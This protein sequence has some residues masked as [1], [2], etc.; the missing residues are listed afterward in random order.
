MISK[1]R[2]Q[3]LV[4]VSTLR[5]AIFSDNTDVLLWIASFC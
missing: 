3:A 1:V 4:S 5:S 2:D